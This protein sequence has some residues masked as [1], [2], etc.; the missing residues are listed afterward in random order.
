MTSSSKQFFA[1]IRVSTLKQG[2]QGSSLQEQRGAI[3]AYAQRNGISIVEWF[4]ERVTAAKR[5]RSVFA[6]MLKRLERGGAHGIII[7]KIDRSARNLRDWADLADL[8]DRGAEVHFA[9]DDVDLR[10]RGG[11]LSAD[12]QAVVAADF[13]RNLREETRKGFY[14]RLKQ[15]LY[16]LRAPIGYLDQGRGQAKAIDPVQGPLVQQAFELY[17]TGDYPFHR[18]RG[19]MHQRGLRGRKGNAVSL[20]GLTTL[21][22]N[23]FYIGLIKISK[24]GEVFE[25]VHPPLVTKALFDRVQSVLRGNR[26]GTPYKNDFLFRR[27]VRCSGCGRSLIGERQ[28]GR[29]IYY[30]CHTIGCPG[31]CLTESVIDS[32]VRAQLQPLRFTQEDFRDFRDLV[33]ERADGR[34]TEREDREAA[35]RLLIGKCDERIARMTDALIDGLIDKETFDQRK[36]DILSEKR[37]HLD[38]L[39][40]IASAPSLADCIKANVELANSAYLNYENG[41]YAEKRDIV[42]SLTSNFEGNG[43]SPAITLKSPFQ[44]YWNWR[45]LNDCD[46]RRDEHRTCV[47]KILDIFTSV[48]EKEISAI[49]AERA[50]RAADIKAAAND[51]QLKDAT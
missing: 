13:I 28:K 10:S 12:I 27:M 51:N 9:H 32:Q 34:A 3:E 11:R 19:E 44:E 39:D 26:I 38:Q 1:Y 43:K 24:T 33:D 25:G 18:L 23:T 6:R 47:S 8:I 15:G 40:N 5:G 4:E 17:A 20:N 46:H 45:V 16:P 36:A 21:L 30:R 50:K 42:L 37:G 35:F 22:N 14:G 2:T 41:N 7:H 48:A 31:A 29:H 49:L